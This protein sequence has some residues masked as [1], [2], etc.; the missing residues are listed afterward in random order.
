MNTQI[1]ERIGLTP[2]EI[3]AYLA[4]LSLGPSSTGPLARKSQ[5]SRSKLY[6]IMDKLE[7][8]GLAS[9]AERNGVTYYQAVE[10]AKVNDYLKEKEEELRGLAEDFQE[11][12]PKLE[13]YHKHAGEAQQATIYQGLRGLQACYE[14]YYLKLKKGEEQLC[15]GVPAYQPE[16]HHR[17]WQKD[18][19]KRA[20]A[21][22]RCRML[23]N[24]DAPRATLE[25]RNGYALCDARYMPTDIKT[26]AYFII[27]ADTTMIA[28]PSEEPIAIE[29]IN[30][31]IADAFRA[32]FE[33]FW[34]QSKRFR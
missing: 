23:F 8:K 19:V 1:L 11:F 9:H 27:Y 30:K 3:K 22:I 13:A 34:K 7:K 10:P 4:L 32:Y 21:G 14:H 33:E 6:S 26:P 5:V 28:I 20:A 29:I 17:Y 18:H 16:A 25:N 12:L 24:R 2:G 31:N 15:I